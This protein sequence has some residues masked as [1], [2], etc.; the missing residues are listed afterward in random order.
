MPC[1]SRRSGRGAGCC[2]LVNDR[3]AAEA[4]LEHKEIL[5]SY[6]HS[7]FYM[8]EYVPKPGRDIRA[9]VV[10][11]EMHLRHLPVLAA[12]DHQHGARRPRPRTARSRRRSPTSRCAPRRRGRRSAGGRSAGDA[13]AACWSRGELTMEFRNSID[14]TGVNIPAGMVDYVINQA[15]AG[16]TGGGRR[17]GG[18]IAAG[19]RL[20]SQHHRQRKFMRRVPDIRHATPW[21]GGPRRW[22]RQRHRLDRPAEPAAVVS[23]TRGHGPR[24]RSNHELR[25]GVSS[26]ADPWTPRAPSWRCRRGGQPVPTGGGSGGR[27]RGRRGRSFAWCASPGSTARAGRA[28]HWRAGR[29]SAI[30][31]GYKG[32]MRADIRFA[33]PGGHSAGKEPS[34]AE[35]P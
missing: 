34:V 31:L 18:G 26:A 15:E 5:G 6:H 14:T 35:C 30:V 16:L 9:F 4:I 17:R 24:S 27:G 28:D 29:F 23:G 8:Q 1:S 22:R 19:G 2:R 21:P 33:M 10:G 20:D 3:D 25:T 32:S 13:I 12:L 11:D 7:I